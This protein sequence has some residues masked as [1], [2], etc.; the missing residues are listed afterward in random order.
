MGYRRP[1]AVFWVPAWAIN[2]PNRWG[3]CNPGEVTEP[4]PR[5]AGR[6]R[7]FTDLSTGPLTPMAGFI[8]FYMEKIDPPEVSASRGSESGRLR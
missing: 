2:S 4:N 7:S 8:P 5:S 1:P 6:S 3:N